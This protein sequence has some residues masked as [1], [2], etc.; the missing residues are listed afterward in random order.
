MCH[1]VDEVFVVRAIERKAN[2][3]RAKFWHLASTSDCG[4]VI[5]CAM[6]LGDV[7]WQWALM[8]GHANEFGM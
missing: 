1:Y 6:F 2:R 7:N 5:G 3:F 8:D 4:S